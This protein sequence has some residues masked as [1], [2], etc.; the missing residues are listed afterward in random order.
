MQLVEVNAGGSVFFLIFDLVSNTSQQQHHQQQ[1]LYF[2]QQQQQQQQHSLQLQH[3]RCTSHGPSSRLS[4]ATNSTTSSSDGSSTTGSSSSS[5]PSAGLGHSVSSSAAGS[6]AGTPAGSG[7]VSTEG[8]LVV[9]V[10][11]SRLA[12]QAEQFANELTRHLGI[13]APDCR[14]IR[15]VSWESL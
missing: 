11:G 9:K 13:A 12:M 8:V 2:Q 5:N 6:A 1:D 15:Q 10:S 7:V 3:L 14:I 4:V